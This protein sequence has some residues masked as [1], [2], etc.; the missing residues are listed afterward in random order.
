MP[1]ERTS[2]EVAGVVSARLVVVTMAAAVFLLSMIQTLVVPVLPEIGTQLG[3]SATAV[4]WVTTSTMLTASA[5]TPLLGRI[6]DVFGHRRVILAA[7]VVTLAGSVL[8]AVTHS[9]GLL[10]LGRVLQGA[11]FGLFPLAISVLRQSLP[12]EKLT[13]AMAITAS[14]LGVGSG[15]ALV[16]TGL[17]TQGDADYRRIFWLCVGMTL[18]VLA[19]AAVAIPRHPGQGGRVDYRGAAVLGVGL[20]CLLLP[21][22]QGHTWGWGSPKVIGLFA[23]AV[24]VLVGFVALQRRTR[25]PLVTFDLLVRRPVLATNIAA[26][27]IGFAMFSVFL[28][29]T[30]FV[31]TPDA[32]AG[33]GFH[34]SVLRTS[35]L[36]MLPGAVVSMFTGPLAGRLVSRI[37][38]RLVL[39]LACVIGLVGMVLLAA[40]HATTAEMIIGVVICNAAIA[41]AYAA[42]PALLVMNI[43]AHETGVANS[44]NSIMRTVGG[45]IGSALVVTILASQVA[46]HRLP[47]GPVTLPTESAFVLTFGLGGL[48]FLVAALMALFGVPRAAAGGGT[49]TAAEIRED[50]ALGLAGE[51]A[52]SSIDLSEP[53]PAPSRS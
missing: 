14:A 47:S 30:Y 51:F 34:A 41:I 33:Y 45:A 12:R 20:V 25:E 22:S 39:L 37:G 44:I 40:L 26:L 52:T 11:S 8:A 29:V 2:T 21:L 15:I 10:I 3:A 1:H 49:L 50:E 16:A 43:G 53:P 36:F 7:L 19:L 28:G 23:A 38:P 9:I 46:T 24:V 27:C 13:G 48:F 4:G 42:M 35:V 18:V 5:V 6:G 17:L 32:V 31:E